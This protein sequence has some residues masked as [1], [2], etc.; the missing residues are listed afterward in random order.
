MM[1]MESRPRHMDYDPLV[2]SRGVVGGCSQLLL[3]ESHEE[4]GVVHVPAGEEIAV[5]IGTFDAMHG[6][7]RR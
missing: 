2:C 7:Y 5:T 6:L 4:P 3:V 1:P